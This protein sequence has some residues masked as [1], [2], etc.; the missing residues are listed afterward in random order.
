MLTNDPDRFTGRREAYQVG[1]ELIGA[2]GAVAD[3]E[4]KFVRRPE[5]Q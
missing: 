5:K 3:A 1:A 2:S 4:V